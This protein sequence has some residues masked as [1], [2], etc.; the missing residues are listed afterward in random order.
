VSVRP[1]SR[2]F[3]VVSRIALLVLAASAVAAGTILALHGPSGSHAAIRYACPM[4]PEVRAAEPGQC[5]ICR[6]ALEPA[7]RDPGAARPP[8]AMADTTAVDN[9]RKHRIMDFVRKRSLLFDAR[10]LRGP[11]WVEDDGAVTALF[12]DDQVAA[13][14][15]DERGSFTL[16]QTP[17]LSFPMRRTGEAAVRWDGSTS[18]IRFRLDV[19]GAGT[20][21]RPG[22]VGW[23]EVPRKAREVL[24]VPASALLQS[25]D[26]PYV[27]LPAGGNEFE[28]RPIQIGETFLKQGFA[29]VLSGLHAHDR[30]VA[31]ATF[32]IDADRRLGMR[33]A[34]EDGKAP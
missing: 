26:G 4:H 29:V 11:A 23:L 22:Q 28:K 1:V 8:G 30:V 15:S 10:D 25:P 27:L 34:N 33:A 14:A 5:P 16:A 21:P 32:F 31:R 3:I 2:T 12:Y 7:H 17:A 24:T 9:V 6:M 18:R 13:L 20:K 19:A